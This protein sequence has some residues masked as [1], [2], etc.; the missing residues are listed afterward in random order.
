MTDFSFIE[1]EE[2]RAKA[3]EEYNTALQSKITEEV[4]GLKRKNEEL[5]NEKKQ[6]QKQYEEFK[7]QF[8]DID[9]A[10]AKEAFDLIKN[11]ER[12]ELL[13]KGKLDEY[14]KAEIQTKTS[15]VEKKYTKQFEE[16]QFEAKT[17]AEKATK[18]ESLFK[19]KMVDDEL[20]DVAV[21]AGVAPEAIKDFIYVGKSIFKYYES[22]RK[23]TAKDSDGNYLKTEDGKYLNPMEWAEAQK[24]E[25]K[26]W[27]PL[28]SG[29]GAQ[30]GGSNVSMRNDIM[31]RMEDAV[32]KGDMS[33]FR[34][35]KA[36]LKK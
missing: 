16:I 30:G 2:L 21:K 5:L 27:F 13:E 36:S 11:S 35:L 18:Y 3:I 34:R 32:N 1:N 24:K 7:S 31:A 14:I 10:K 33:E 26:Y 29:I 15:E 25:R 20:R 8:G 12:K 22:E 19:E 17:Y 4:S 23:A 6:T 28:S 9:P